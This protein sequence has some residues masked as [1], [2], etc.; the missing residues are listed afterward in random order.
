MRL[1]YSIL[2]DENLKE[3]GERD[4][5]E[6]WFID[7]SNSD[8][9][10]PELEK[11]CGF[12]RDGDEVGVYYSNEFV[13]EIFKR[14]KELNIFP[15]LR[16]AFVQFDYGEDVIDFF[17]KV[18][19]TEIN[20]ESIMIE[21]QNIC[22]VNANKYISKMYPDNKGEGH[23]WYVVKRDVWNKYLEYYKDHTT[24]KTE[25]VKKMSNIFGIS[26]YIATKWIENPEP[27]YFV[28]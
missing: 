24:N 26:K 16:T 8:V 6:K 13:R 17:S 5:I 19:G 4:G 27:K 23:W 2:P 28:D 20:N 9:D 14:I 15:K 3:W 25:L 12:L 11:L 21:K 10:L 7:S 18:F 1:G 22:E